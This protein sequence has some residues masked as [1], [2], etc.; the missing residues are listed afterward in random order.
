LVPSVRRWHNRDPFWVP[1][2]VAVMSEFTGKRPTGDRPSATTSGAAPAPGKRTLVEQTSATETPVQRQASP[3]AQRPAGLEPERVHEA[4]QHGPSGSG[5]S[6]PHLDRI[7][8][9]FGRHDVSGVRAHTDERAA[10][11]ARAMGAEAF[12]DGEHVAFGGAPSLHTAA[13]EA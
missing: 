9:A 7:Q 3:P 12:A 6:L 10:E 2:G 4:A 11:G 8:R 5:G 1:G 13:H